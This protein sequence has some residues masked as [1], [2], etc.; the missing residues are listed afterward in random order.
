[1][2]MI[3]SYVLACTMGL[4]VAGCSSLPFSGDKNN[5]MVELPSSKIDNIP[6]WFLHKEQDNA[7]DIVV[8]ATDT[9][10]DMQ[11][12]IDKATLNAKIQLAERLGTNVDSLTRESALESGYGVKEVEREIDRV[13]KVRIKQD[14][15]FFRREQVAVVREK[16]YYR[17]FVMFKIS[18]DE[19]RRIV[20]SKNNNSNTREEKLKALDGDKE[21][22]VTRVR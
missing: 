11:F 13:S 9:S 20:T 2:R 1:M 15:S 18:R 8:T 17:A 5:K 10:K 6:E 4:I 19:G 14:L 22:S 21:V 7:K 16:D 3:I 12:A